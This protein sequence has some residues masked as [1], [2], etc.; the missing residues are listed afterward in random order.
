MVRLVKSISIVCGAFVFSALPAIAATTGNLVANGG[1]EVGATGD[2][3]A[4]IVVPQGWTT[5]GNFT[6]VKYGSSGLPDTASVSAGRL[7]NRRYD[8]KSPA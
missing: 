1:A 2:S 4:A 7:K 5:S 8:E 6:A 3:D